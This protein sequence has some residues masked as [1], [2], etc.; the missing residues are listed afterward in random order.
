[1]IA[2]TNRTAA[3]I[4]LAVVS[5]P[6]PPLGH[7]Q[8]RDEDSRTRQLWD[9]AFTRRRRS[10][11][12]PPAAVPSPGPAP[13]PRESPAAPG[14]DPGGA[15]GPAERLDLADSLIG[16]TVWRLRPA[17]AGDRDQGA[18]VFAVGGEDLVA[19][20]VEAGTSLAPGDRVRIGVESARPGYL[21][22]IDREQFAGGAG[23]PFLIFPRV[24]IRGG[25]NR[26]MPGRLVEV[27]DLADTPPFFTL[28][29]SRPDQVG[30]LVTVIVAPQPIQ[31]LPA[32]R[33]AQRLSPEQ[34]EAWEKAWAAPTR[35]IELPGGAGTLYTG[36]EREAGGMASRLLTQEEPVPQSMYRVES[37]PGD[38]MMVQLS[39][40]MSKPD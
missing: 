37:K 26:V 3:V 5:V 9:D 10:K 23:D 32:G 33:A 27:P 15:T 22:L 1:M 21:Y 17:R 4:L 12:V 20:R 7:A 40:R 14:P 35:R 28:K 19:Q 18:V 25:D 30:E 34:V 24:R 8:V 31:G 11:S 13:A 29:P 36:A 16:I 39:L 6:V 2:A 38:P